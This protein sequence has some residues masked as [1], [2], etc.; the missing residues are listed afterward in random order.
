MS[1]CQ[2]I[3]SS[4]FKRLP[5]T[6]V[7]KFPNN[8]NSKHKATWLKGR[9]TELLNDHVDKGFPIWKHDSVK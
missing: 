5:K 8:A 7:K 4:L 9:A 2:S 6:Q 1:A 3:F